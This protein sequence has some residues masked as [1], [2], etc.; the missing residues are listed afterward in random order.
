MKEPQGSGSSIMKQRMGL[1]LGMSLVLSCAESTHDFPALPAEKAF[2]GPTTAI[3]P[4]CQ[5]PWLPRLSRLHL[6]AHLPLLGPSGAAFEVRLHQSASAYSSPRWAR[7]SEVTLDRLGTVQ[8]DLRLVDPSGCS[9][10]H[11]S[12]RYEVVHD[13]ERTDTELSGS[14]ISI[15]DEE[16]THWADAVNTYEP[17][18]RVESAFQEVNRALGKAS[19]LALD[20][21][22]LGSGGRIELTFDPPIADGEGP[23]F[24]VFEN[25][26]SAGFLELAYVEVSSNGTDFVRFP[27]IYLGQQPLG[28]F[29]EIE[30]QIMSGLAGQYPAGF[31]VGF[32]LRILA[33]SPETQDG[34]L[35]LHQVSHVRL[36]D[37]VGDGQHLDSFGHP[38][39][40]PYPTTDSAGFDL[41]AIGVLNSAKTHPCPVSD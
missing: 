18:E 16:I 26:F 13:F 11:V 6:G 17:G 37:I 34:R 36:V 39:Y 2:C 12:R 35:D 21:V 27:N 33:W 25:G 29:S 40:D 8:I 38:I 15:D 22:S 14:R 31:G 3:E 20:V 24:A 30:G 5:L 4:A 19:G 41:D 32:D 9:T 10:T 1:I 28:P 7:R 23:D